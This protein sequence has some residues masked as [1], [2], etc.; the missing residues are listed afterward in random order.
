MA[1]HKVSCLFVRAADVTAAAGSIIAKPAAAGSIIGYVTDI[2]LRDRV[3]AIQ[4]DPKEPVSTVMDTPIVSIPSSAFVFE[5]V[6]LMFRTK[7]RYLLVE[8]QG[9]YTGFLSRNKLLSEQAQSPLVFIQS[10][11]SAVSTDELKGV[12]K[13]CLR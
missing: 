7:A 2:T 13:W 5:A 8:R 9:A 11:K 3:L 1:E 4:G 12:G 10:V 6:L